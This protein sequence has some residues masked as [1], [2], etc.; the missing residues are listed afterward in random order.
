MKSLG[1][2]HTDQIGGSQTGNLV[3]SGLWK[4]MAGMGKR[5]CAA[6]TLG[7]EPSSSLFLRLV[8]VG[9]GELA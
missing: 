9:S 8:E 4:K 1:R 7:S 3:F 6:G 2:D 5:V